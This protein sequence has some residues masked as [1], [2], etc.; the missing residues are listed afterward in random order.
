[1]RG[2]RP[3]ARVL[4]SCPSLFAFWYPQ[5]ANVVGGTVASLALLGS[6]PF[7]QQ[8]IGESGVS[9]E[10]LEQIVLG[11]RDGELTRDEDVVG[12]MLSN[13]REVDEFL[14]A[15]GRKWSRRPDSGK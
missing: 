15:L 8:V 6:H 10:I 14:D 12:K 4:C 7:S 11:I 2:G 9:R 5:P 1:M 13:G 3:S